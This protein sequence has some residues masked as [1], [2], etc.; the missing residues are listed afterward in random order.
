MATDKPQRQIKFRAWHGKS[1][2]ML[3]LGFNWGYE[4]E[5]LPVN[6]NWDDIVRVEDLIF[7]QFTGL[8][9]KNGKG[10]WEGDIFSMFQGSQRSAIFWDEEFGAWAV[11]AQQS[12]AS[13]IQD[14]L[15][16][17]LLDTG[18]VIGNIYENPD[19]L[20]KVQP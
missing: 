4:S 14:D 13:Q 8:T 2:R 11:T 19:L 18:Y 10:I 17:N 6:G 12:G 20:G 9:D 7:L 1:K 15:L 5:C 16:S 3:M